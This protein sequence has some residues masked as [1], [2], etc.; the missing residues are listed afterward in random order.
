MW[1]EGLSPDNNNDDNNDDDTQWAIHDYIDL[2]A[3]M[4]N[5]PKFYYAF[6]D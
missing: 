5:E 6:Q 2:L 1:L 3:F 4:P